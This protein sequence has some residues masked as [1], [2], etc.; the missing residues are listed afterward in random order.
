M[1]T[2][3]L[4]LLATATLLALPGAAAADPTPSACTA[5]ATDAQAAL[6][7]APPPKGEPPASEQLQLEAEAPQNA[8]VPAPVP[9]CP[10]QRPCSGS[11]C[12]EGA[13]CSFTSL[14]SRCCLDSALNR[15][16]C[17]VGQTVFQVVCPCVGASCTNATKQTALCF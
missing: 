11:D 10:E 17:P 12:V 15:H 9:V 4:A 16:C 14:G 2:T 13:P 6:A 7:G 8:A 5:T 3:F 1:K